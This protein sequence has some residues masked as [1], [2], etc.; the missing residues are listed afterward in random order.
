MKKIILIIS[1][2]FII[3][4]CSNPEDT[5]KIKE[6]ENKINNLEKQIEWIILKENELIKKIDKKPEETYNKLYDEII[7]KLSESIYSEREM[8][9]WYTMN[10][11]WE[12]PYDEKYSKWVKNPITTNK[13]LL[14]FCN[15]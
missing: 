12:N 6:L 5:E 4:S 13:N 15:K 3:S 9:A 1:M 10:K 14:I 2:L 11:W 8:I 7:C